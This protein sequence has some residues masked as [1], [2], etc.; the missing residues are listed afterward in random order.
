[1]QAVLVAAPGIGSRRHRAAGERRARRITRRSAPRH[2]GPDRNCRAPKA[3]ASSN[4]ASCKAWLADSRASA[5][6]APDAA[7]A[8]VDVASVI[9]RFA[10]GRTI[11]PST[12]HRRARAELARTRRADDGARG[13]DAGHASTNRRFAAAATVADLEAMTRPIEAGTPRPRVRSRQPSRSS[14]R[15]GID[16]RRSVRLRR[17]SLPT[18]ILP[19]ARVFVSLRRRGLEHWTRSGVR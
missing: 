1:M 2:S 16:P 6:P 12:T 15:P 9:E 13:N 3:R 7:D 5:T 18:W 14:S 19:L 10:P 11:A 4:A 17:A 8:A